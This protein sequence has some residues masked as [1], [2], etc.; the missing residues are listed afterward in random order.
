MEGTERG[1][2]EFQSFL[3]LLNISDFSQEHSKMPAL[4]V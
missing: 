3:T 1:K 4:E 2:K